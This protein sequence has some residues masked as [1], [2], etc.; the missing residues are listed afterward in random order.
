M[1]PGLDIALRTARLGLRPPSE[2]DVVAWTALQRRNRARLA[3]FRPSFAHQDLPVGLTA[4]A[5]WVVRE[6]AAWEHDKAYGFV[7]RE[8]A[9]G[10]LVGWGGLGHVQ[11]GAR[12]RAEVA[13]WV[14]ARVEGRGYAVEAAAALVDFAFG[15]LGLHRVEALVHHQNERS[16][17]A[18]GRAGFVHEG[19]LRGLLMI[20][21]RWEDH[22][23]YAKLA[24]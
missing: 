14:D 1:P 6:R 22:A 15:P 8:N 18:L 4:S 12:Q 2:D 19:V 9:G 5:A 11:R 13:L 23:L 16:Q 17:R 7:L 24:P 20:D 21:G 10:N 3:S